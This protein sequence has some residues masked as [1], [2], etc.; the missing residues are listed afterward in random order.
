MYGSNQGTNI[1]L[2]QVGSILAKHDAVTATS[3]HVFI[4]I[5]FLTCSKS[6]GIFAEIS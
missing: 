4:A 3:G 5:Q 2:G 1:G 6:F